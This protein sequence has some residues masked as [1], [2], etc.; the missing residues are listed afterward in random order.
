MDDS[1]LLFCNPVS[2]LI[3]L[4]ALSGFFYAKNNEKY[5][6]KAPFI[7][8][9]VGL[10]LSV[11]PLLLDDPVLQGFSLLLFIPASVIISLF[12]FVFS[13]SRTANRLGTDVID[14][15]KKNEKSENIVIL[16]VYLAINFIILI[17]ICWLILGI[18]T[19][20]LVLDIPTYVI[21]LPFALLAISIFYVFFR[22]LSRKLYNIPVAYFLLAIFFMIG[23]SVS[24]ILFKF[25]MNDKYLTLSHV[26]QNCVFVGI[27]TWLVIKYQRYLKEQ[28]LIQNQNEIQL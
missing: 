3:I 4:A 15:K 9:G 17:K 2:I 16:Y 1:I 27:S 6:N 12:Y 23:N 8:L 7:I 26:L 5:I 21:D 14:N 11:C 20:K 28:Q 19:N 22:G 13:L 18:I 24:P 10:I 25:A